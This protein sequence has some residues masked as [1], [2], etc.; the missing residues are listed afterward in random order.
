MGTMNKQTRLIYLAFVSLSWS[1][2]VEAQ[3]PF[4][5]FQVHLDGSVGFAGNLSVDIE[6]EGEEPESFADKPLESSLGGY[7]GASLPIGRWF[8]VEAGAALLA[9]RTEEMDREGRSR[10]RVVDVIAKPRARL[11]V[12]A[13]ELYAAMPVGLSVPRIADQTGPSLRVYGT[14]VSRELGWSIGAAAGVQAF[15]LS[16]LGVRAEVGY[17]K[18][19]FGYSLDRV[20]PGTS[21]K[22]SFHQI[23]LSFGVVYAI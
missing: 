7:L 23:L 19:S 3:D 6:I 22:A 16:S 1:V 8:A 14:E 9:W 4:Q 10:E 20:V 15:V 11:R 13:V 2:P 5:R 18:H 21:F 12:G 17:Q